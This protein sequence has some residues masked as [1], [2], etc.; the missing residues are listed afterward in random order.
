ML[1]LIYRTEAAI[2]GPRAGNE[3]AARDGDSN[4]GV[5]FHLGR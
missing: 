2:T 3:E 1:N 5:V 4:S